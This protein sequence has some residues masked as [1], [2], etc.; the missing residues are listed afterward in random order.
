MKLIQDLDNVYE[1]SNRELINKTERKLFSVNF[2]MSKQLDKSNET[3]E[4]FLIRFTICVT[5]LSMSNTTKINHLDRTMTLRY[6]HKSSHLKE[7][8]IFREYL[9]EIRKINSLIKSIDNRIDISAA[10][11]VR[12][13]TS[14]NTTTFINVT[15]RVKDDDKNKSKTF[16]LTRFSAHVQKKI[17]FEERCVKCFKSNHISTQTNASCKNEK[18]MLIKK[19]QTKLSTIDFD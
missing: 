10:T 15:T 4:N 8:N 12:I 1:I 9:I 13:R 17:K 19:I 7:T 2:S 14:R 3:L 5:F 6:I 16:Y 11:Q 18:L